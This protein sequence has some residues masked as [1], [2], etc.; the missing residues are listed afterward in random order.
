MKV[1]VLNL[2]L[3]TT[4]AIVAAKTSRSSESQRIVGG[5]TAEEGLAPYQVSLQWVW[6]SNHFCG[7]AIIDPE[8]ILTAAHCVAPATN[9]ES[10]VVETG[11]QNLMEPGVYYHVDR[12]YSH[13]SYND[14]LLH[15]DIALLHLNSSIV[16]N[17]KTQVIP[18][19]VEPMEDGDDVLLTGWGAESSNGG[20]GPSKLKKL[21]LKYVKYE[22]C[23]ALLDND[24]RLD[25]GNICTFLREGEGACF[26]DSG[27]PLVS[28]GHLVG[29][30][31]FANPCALG[32]PDAH[33]SPYF[34]LDWIRQIMRGNKKCSCDS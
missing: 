13:C 21:N 7:G 3:L 18:L 14:P 22:R 31:S 34:Y 27:G 25:V 26:G 10:L 12:I 8:W 2:F 33:A 9:P 30:V 1:S 16:M 5:N 24:P 6:G 28:N 4:T 15:N 20:S 29:I 32:F 11:T 23:K 17:K 19:P